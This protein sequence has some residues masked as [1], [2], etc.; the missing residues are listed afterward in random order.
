MP[1]V[2]TQQKD[3]Q[4]LETASGRARQE[5]EAVKS[6]GAGINRPRVFF[7][8]WFQ[9]RPKSSHSTHALAFPAFRG[10][11][12]SKDGR[13]ESHSAVQRSPRSHSSASLRSRSA[14]ALSFVARASLRYR[15]ARRLLM[16]SQIPTQQEQ[17]QVQGER[18]VPGSFRCRSI[19]SVAASG[20]PTHRQRPG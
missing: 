11:S 2:E 18:L 9:C 1:N 14:S 3:A 13:A 10:V 17:D 19:G 16:A 15:T 6:K 5:A 12:L 7:A 4:T 20:W 8:D